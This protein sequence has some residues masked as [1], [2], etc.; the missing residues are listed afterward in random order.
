VIG[1]GSTAFREGRDD[2]AAGSAGPA[3]TE[4]ATEMTVTSDVCEGPGRAAVREPTVKSAAPCS[5]AARPRQAPRLPRDV[6]KCCR[7]FTS[8]RLRLDVFLEDFVRASGS[9]RRSV[10]NRVQRSARQHSEK[11]VLAMS[12]LISFPVA[13]LVSCE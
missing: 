3:S 11:R 13:G 6:R 2:S 7:G 4:G 10:G 1:C 9:S 8:N 5:A 12:E